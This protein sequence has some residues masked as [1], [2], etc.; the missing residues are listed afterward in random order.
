MRVTDKATGASHEQEVTLD[1][2]E[3]P[4]PDTT[5]AK[6]AALK[7]VYPGGTTTA[8]NAS[9]LSAPAGGR[10]PEVAPASESKSLRHSSQ[11]HPDFHD[12]AQRQRVNSEYTAAISD[13]VEVVV[14]ERD[15]AHR[16]PSVAT[17][18]VFSQACTYSANLRRRVASDFIAFSSRVGPP[19]LAA[20]ARNAATSALSKWNI[21]ARASLP[22]RTR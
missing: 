9:Q 20:F 8:G 1:R 7:P 22:F 14:L 2:D 16:Q 13:I 6:L 15:D 18:G 3:G 12:G 21:C 4:R 5:L 10:G 17:P 19:Q 11:A